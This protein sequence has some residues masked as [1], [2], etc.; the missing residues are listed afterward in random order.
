MGLGGQCPAA[1]PPPPSVLPFFLH[2]R[3]KGVPW[4]QGFPA[5]TPTPQCNQQL[6]LVPRPTR[7]AS[8]MTGGC[9]ALLQLCSTLTGLLP[10]EQQARAALLGT[11]VS[12]LD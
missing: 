1:R 8:V 2:G 7:E 12:R 10:W 4:P 9:T 6:P 11:G 3:T 5:L